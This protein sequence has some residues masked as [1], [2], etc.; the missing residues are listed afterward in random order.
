MLNKKFIKNPNERNESTYK[1]YHN[2]FNK[3]KNLAKKYYY[4]KEFNEHKLG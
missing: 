1:I 4:N 2:K 3:V